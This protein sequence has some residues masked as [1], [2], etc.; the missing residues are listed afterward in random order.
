MRLNFYDDSIIPTSFTVQCIALL[1]MIKSELQDQYD[2][3]EL[4]HHDDALSGL[5]QAKFSIFFYKTAYKKSIITKSPDN[6][7]IRH[8]LTVEKGL[9]L[10]L[11]C[12]QVQKY[13]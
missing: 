7:S 13:V 4:T 10:L 11:G 9:S 6:L 12:F 1:G 8:T 5:T 2:R 3:V